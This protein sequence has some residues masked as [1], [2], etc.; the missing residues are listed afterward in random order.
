[1]PSSSSSCR[2]TKYMSAHPTMKPSTIPISSLGKITIKISIGLRRSS[3]WPHVSSA[4][5]QVGPHVAGHKGTNDWD[6]KLD[7]EHQE[8]IHLHSFFL[9]YCCNIGEIPLTNLFQLLLDRLLPFALLIVSPHI[10]S[11]LP[12]HTI[13]GQISSK[14]DTLCHNNQKIELPY[15]ESCSPVF[16]GL[17]LFSQFNTSLFQLRITWCNHSLW[18]EELRGDECL[19]QPR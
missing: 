3:P 8:A 6:D 13:V 18:Q 12:E 5:E 4:I 7:D 19:C 14:L 17:L 9:K 15:S 11:H 1:M 16:P 10:A 2:M